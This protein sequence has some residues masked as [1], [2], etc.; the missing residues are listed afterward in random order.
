MITLQAKRISGVVHL[1]KDGI[2]KAKYQPDCKQPRKGQKT[3]VLN[4]FTY[5][6]EWI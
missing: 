4:C 1:F 6:L 2:L 3:T 5:K